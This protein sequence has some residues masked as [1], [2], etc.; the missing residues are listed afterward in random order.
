[1]MKTSRRVFLETVSLAAL[2]ALTPV[3][4]NP[5]TTFGDWRD[6]LSDYE[7]STRSNIVEVGG[8]RALLS[9]RLYPGTYIRDALFWGPLAL[10]DAA[11]GLECYQW[12]AESQLES[13]QIRSAVPLHPGEA[14]QLQPQGDEG[15]LLFVIASDWLQRTGHELEAA[16]IVR[17][18][19][20]I[21]THVSGDTYWA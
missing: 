17:A 7:A 5:S 21:Q 8:R 6:L 16:R 2:G 10:G 9:S 14:D 18:Y 4:A 20:W 12:F 19:A 3:H 13:G 15:T 11:L 1:M